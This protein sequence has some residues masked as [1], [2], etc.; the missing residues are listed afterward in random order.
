MSAAQIEIQLIAVVVAIACALPG[1]FLVL[2]RMALLSDAI[3]HSILLG[4]VLG[5]L[6][7]GNLSSP[8]LIIGAA[9]IGIA[10]VVLVELLNGTGLVREDAAIGLVF[11]VLFSIGVILIARKAGNV[12][13]DT[14][15]VLLGELAFAPFDR[16]TIFGADI[17]PTSLILMLGVLI[18]N[19]AFILIFYK[20]LKLA[21]FDAALATALGFSPM[22]LHYSLMLIVSLTCVTAFN[23][24]GSILVVALMIAPPAAA[25]LW[26]D[27]L[28]RMLGLSAL[29]GALSAVTGYWLAHV[30]DASIAGAMAAMCG[31]FFGASLLFAPSHGVVAKWR[32]HRRQQWEF[33]L[34]LLLIHIYTHEDSPAAAYE[35]R[36]EHL[37]EH[38]RWSETF[39]E[40]IVQRAL[41][42]GLLELRNG[43]MNLTETGRQFAKRAIVDLPQPVVPEVHSQVATI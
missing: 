21:T 29:I 8:L 38:I 32:R 31:V 11:P 25:Y 12:H 39:A 1:V 40:R 41:E 9:L 18:V 15:A 43:Q 16:V 20:E 7:V 30:L 34:A 28:D 2:R 23:A 33:S 14:D 35:N 5:F 19:V 13:L 4:I 26:T 3:S 17:G 42:G 10:T 27:R 36:R 37:T 24:V 6:I 22:I